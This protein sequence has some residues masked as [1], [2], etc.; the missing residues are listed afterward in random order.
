MLE[1]TPDIS[2]HDNEVELTFVRASGPGGQNVNKVSSAVQLRFD[3]RGSPSLPGAVKRRLIELAAGRMT[4]EGV[5][6]INARQFRTQERNRQ[7]AIDRLA[8]LIR[9]AAEPPPP[10]RRKTKPSRAARRRR[11]EDKKQQSQKKRLRGRV[12]SDDH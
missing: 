3:V 4:N 8:A 12:R 11:R 9:L 2:L 10:P 1:V 6:L 7:D 5:L